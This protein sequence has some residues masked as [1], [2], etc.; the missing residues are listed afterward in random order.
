MDST[1]NHLSPKEIIYLYEMT[2]QPLITLAAIHHRISKT[3]LGMKKGIY[4]LV[5]LLAAHKKMER[6]KAGWRNKQHIMVIHQDREDY[7]EEML[8]V[9][10]RIY[11]IGRRCGMGESY[12]GTRVLCQDMR[13][14]AKASEIYTLMSILGSAFNAY[15]NYADLNPTAQIPP[16]VAGRERSKFHLR[17]Q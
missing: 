13:R 4:K 11:W 3:C 16:L 9:W 2:F 10:C 8:S 15:S 7:G 5:Y 6:S 14:E 1:Y 17:F 12:M